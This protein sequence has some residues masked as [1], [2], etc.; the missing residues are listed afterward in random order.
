MDQDVE[1]TVATIYNMVT[2]KVTIEDF[3]TMRKTK[4]C[5]PITQRIMVIFN[6]VNTVTDLAITGTEYMVEGTDLA[7]MAEKTDCDIADLAKVT[8]G[9]AT[10]K[11]I[12]NIIMTRKS[13]THPGIIQ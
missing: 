7:D 1:T 6:T 9:M 11:V 5:L 8:Q 12:E 10:E 4:T 13:K 3:T 2:R